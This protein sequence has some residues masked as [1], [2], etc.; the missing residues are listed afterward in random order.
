M[1]PRSECITGSVVSSWFAPWVIRKPPLARWTA[2]HFHLAEKQKLGWTK[3]AR[4]EQRSLLINEFGPTLCL[5]H[6]ARLRL[7]PP[8]YTFFN[9]YFIFTPT[10]W[11]NLTKS[12]P[13]CETFCWVTVSVKSGCESSLSD[14]HALTA[15]HLLIPR[16]HKY[17]T[18]YNLYLMTLLVSNRWS[19][20]K[21]FELS[22]VE[23]FPWLVRSFDS[24]FLEQSGPKSRYLQLFNAPRIT[25]SHF[26]SDLMNDINTDCQPE[27]FWVY[28]DI[29]HIPFQGHFSP[30]KCWSAFNS[31]RK[32]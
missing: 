22:R 28:R 12:F 29:S 25:L 24:L 5:P 9:I 16:L 15:V 21:C 19:M 23:N 17:T 13:T 31:R 11:V 20:R 3:R 1:S 2:A 18:V 4:E 8:V 7:R 27:S 10:D 14:L 30:K 26:H 6:P 32:H